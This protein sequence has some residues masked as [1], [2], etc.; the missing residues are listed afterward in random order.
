[1]TMT[2]LLRQSNTDHTLLISKASVTD[3]KITTTHR[4]TTR[5]FW[6]CFFLSKANRLLKKK[7][8]D[9]L[10]STVLIANRSA[11]NHSKSFHA[12]VFVLLRKGKKETGTSF[13]AS[14]QLLAAVLTLKRHEQ[15]TL[16]LS[17][18]PSVVKLWSVSP[19]LTQIP[20]GWYS[21]FPFICCT[22]WVPAP[23]KSSAQDLYDT[24]TGRKLDSK[25]GQ[26]FTNELWRQS[27]RLGN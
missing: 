20:S 11:R 8:C 17:V 27:L 16:A 2:H 9:L 14:C 15:W 12:G 3:E 1:M 23:S 26:A 24:W 4:Y 18:C 13:L 6:C 10:V 19:P 22:V 21:R 5:A 7:V 25:K